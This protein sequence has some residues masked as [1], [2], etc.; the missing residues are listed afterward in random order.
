MVMFSRADNGHRVG[1]C[2]T[3]A[4][5]SRIDSGARSPVSTSSQCTDP[6]VGRYSPASSA[7]RVDLPDPFSP[8]SATTSPRRSVSVTSAMA[9]RSASG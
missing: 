5:R 9:G 4:T 2:I 7:A 6:S 3:T 8:T 1:S